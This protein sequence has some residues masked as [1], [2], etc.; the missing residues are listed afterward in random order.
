MYLMGRL[1]IS[2]RTFL[3]LLFLLLVSGEGQLWASL[4][5][6]HGKHQPSYKI[7][8]KNKSAT[9]LHFSAKKNQFR[10]QRPHVH[11]SKKTR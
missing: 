3:I 11:Y 6:P 5:H 4:F 10:T 2:F 7:S 9:R 8:R 1:M